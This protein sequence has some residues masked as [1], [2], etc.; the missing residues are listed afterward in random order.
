LCSPCNGVVAP[1]TAMQVI[2]VGFAMQRGGRSLHGG[3]E[4]FL[5]FF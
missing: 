4:N 3:L 1:C 5:F 2:N